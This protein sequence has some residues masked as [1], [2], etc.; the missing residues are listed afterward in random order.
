MSSASSAIAIG[1]WK[2]SPETSELIKLIKHKYE[3]IPA[4]FDEIID[5]CYIIKE[6]NKH[7]VK[8]GMSFCFNFEFDAGLSI[9]IP[10]V[11]ASIRELGLVYGIPELELK[12]DYTEEVNT[13]SYVINNKKFIDKI[14]EDILFN[15]EAIFD[16]LIA[17][18][19]GTDIS[20]ITSSSKSFA[21]PIFLT[22]GAVTIKLIWA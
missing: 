13:V 4:L 15:I 22:L 12:S 11:E 16:S 6:E 21:T 9:L 14:D 5:Q 8:R 17:Q 2:F 3:N 20:A 1:L 18:V 7:L 10:Q 19:I